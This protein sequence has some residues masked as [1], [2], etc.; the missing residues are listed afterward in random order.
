[1]YRKKKSRFK[2]KKGIALVVVLIF[3]TIFSTLAV[4][5]FTM[6]S[7]NTI[8]ANNLH[9]ANEARS[10]AESGLEVVR[11]QLN[12][13]EVL[14]TVPDA[15]RFGLLT[16]FLGDYLTNNNGLS[17]TFDGTTFAIG[18]SDNPIALDSNRGFYAEL[19]Y[20]DAIPVKRET[21]LIET[22]VGVAFTV[23]GVSDGISRTINGGFTYG[24]K[25]N[26]SSVFDFGVATKGPLSLEGNILLDGVNIAVES[27][28][29]IESMDYT[30]AL[31]IIG[32]SQIAGDVKI[33]NPD[34]TVT[35]QGGQAGIGGETG[36]AAIE[37]HVDIGVDQT[38]FPIPDT[39]HFEQYVTGITL[40]STNIDTYSTTGG[41]FENIRIAAN[42]NPHFSAD[43][44]LNGVIFI[45]TPNVVTF[46]GNVDI[47]GII[48]GDGDVTD[49][50]GTNQINITGNVS[51]TSV[52][53][54]P[55]ETY[56]DLTTEI[57]TFMMVPGFAVDFGGSF[58]TLNGCIAANGV[59]FSGNAGGVIGGSVLNYSN[60]P[61]G[62]SGNSDLF[63]NRSN[64]TDVP[65]G[66]T[67]VY[68]IVIRYQPISYSEVANA[69]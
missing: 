7:N 27:D 42:T 57:G 25:E 21:G 43:V 39:S 35:L 24:E 15:D 69:L 47:A 31:E 8:V 16:T 46:T 63:F 37:N 20:D 12:Q 60:E 32:N 56:G 64:T 13:F 5:M 18:S 19:H 41:T 4:A 1:M 45:E 11:Y 3:V 54:L 51:S 66:F 38:N 52:S 61:M 48:I 22:T 62:L 30:N 65:A 34:G 59:S 28:V 9:T 49:N 58:D 55:V 14:S 23:V 44:Q 17:Y 36:T 40:D 68:D 2:Q 29:Y 33:V 50:S 67:P 53:E 26:I 10:A 6:S